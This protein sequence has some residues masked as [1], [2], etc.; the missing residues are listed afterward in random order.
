MQTVPHRSTFS[1][2]PLAVLAGA[3]AAGILIAHT[4]SLPLRTILA[5]AA[6]ALLT[7]VVT[8]LKRRLVAASLLIILATL[9][10]GAALAAIEQQTPRANQLKQLLN[11]GVIA[12]GDPVE[13]TGVLAAPPE[14]APDS[15]YLTLDVEQV[16]FKN[17]TRVSFGTIELLAPARDQA[18]RAEYSALELRYGA[19]IRVMTALERT[20]NYRNPGVSSFTEYL[21]RKDYDAAGAIKSPLL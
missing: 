5:T 10:A 6:A 17:A 1:P 8:L 21:D 19:R 20:D 13:L 16:T 4:L 3:F 9:F 15:F 11:D 2:H 12:S 18:T 14:D 7:V